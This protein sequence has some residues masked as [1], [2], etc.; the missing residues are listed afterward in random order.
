MRGSATRKM[1][2]GL[3]LVATLGVLVVA[4]QQG[5]TLDY[6]LTGTIVTID[7]GVAVD[8]AGMTV[9]RACYDR[10][11]EMSAD[12]TEVVPALAK[13]W[14]VSEDGLTYTFYLVDNATFHDGSPVNADAVKYSLDRSL[15]LGKGWSDMLIEAVAEG[16]VAV[17]NDYELT[18]TLTKSTPFFFDL[19]AL[20]GPASVVNPAIVEANITEDDPYA[21]NYLYENTA[22]SGA[23]KLVEWSHGQYL[24]MERNENYWGTPA[25]LDEVIMRVVPEAST[26]STMVQGGDLDVAANLPPEVFQMLDARDDVKVLEFSI[27][28]FAA[29]YF[30]CSHEILSNVLVRQALSYAYDYET[31]LAVVGPGNNEMNGL[32]MPGMLGH[33]PERAPYHQDFDKARELLDE[34]GYPDGFSMTC[35]YPPWGVIPELMVVAQAAFAQVGVDMEIQEIAFGPYL[36][37]VNNGDSPLF[38][39]VGSPSINDPHAQL[40][41]RVHSSQIGTGSGGNINNYSDAAVDALLEAG[42]NETDQAKRAEIYT[43]VDRIL[44][45]QAISIWQYVEAQQRAVRE[46]VHGFIWPVIGV[47]DFSIVYMDAE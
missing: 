27:L 4:Q 13:S 8:S 46:N 10:L 9:I 42:L 41:S 31:T 44:F 35:F 3:L 22:G 5:G 33:D 38:A 36:E 47:P 19:L 14:T 25:Y 37:A 32:L 43:Q 40:Y 30:D 11:V 23:F 26:A 12:G 34:A 45:E 28:A 1:L 15:A 6:G 7:P 17:V 21:E 20:A 2:V 39:W 24:A 16:G 29:F 18:I